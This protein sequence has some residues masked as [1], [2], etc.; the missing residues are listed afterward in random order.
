VVF[1][2][3][4]VEYAQM[5]SGGR[6]PDVM[7]VLRN[8]LGCLLAFACC[9]RQGRSPGERGVRWLFDGLTLLLMM[10]AAWPLTR[11][12]I[13][14]QLAVRQFPILS[15]FETPFEQYRW[16]NVRQ[17]R[18]ESGLVRHGK[19]AMRIQLS[20]A[21]YS[22]IALFHFPGDWRG[23]RMVRCSV[24]NPLANDLSLNVRIHDTPHK[25]H[26]SEFSDRFNTQVA[27]HPG[28]N[29][30]AIDLDRVRTAPAGRTMDMGRIE[31]FGL[32]VVQQA[33][34]IEIILDHVVLTR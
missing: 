1:F 11:A 22:G 9:I 32:F 25:R 10:V 16:M 31:G 2:G 26:G 6:S 24:F 34:P 33:Q 19:K 8:Q 23:Y 4:L 29:D 12:L 7:D 13:D 5:F 3:V 28:W 15:D 27:L 20:T 17:M 21:R 18:A 14:E 30:L